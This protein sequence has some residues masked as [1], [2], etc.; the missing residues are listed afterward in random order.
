MTHHIDM[1]RLHIHCFAF[2][3][4]ILAIMILVFAV[5]LYIYDIGSMSQDLC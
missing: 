3:S 4:H 1:L 5:A 2:K